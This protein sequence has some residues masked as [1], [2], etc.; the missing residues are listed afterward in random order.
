MTKPF[1]QACENNKAP[2][3][4]VLESV[5]SQATRVLEIGSGTGQHA[6]HFAAALPHVQWQTSDVPAHHEGINAWLNEAALP[7]LLPPVALQVGKDAFPA[8]G[9]DAV[10]S[11]N[12]AHIMFAD[13]VALM[14]TGIAELLPDG[15]VFCQ[16]GPFIQQG[17]FSSESNRAF[18]HNLLL[19]GLGGY[20]SIEDLQAW[21][22]VSLKLKDI[23]AMPA[24]NLCLL[25]QKQVS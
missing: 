16:Y 2:I 17:E 24:N 25:W 23:I 14:M 21:S 4:A 7:N 13:E 10:Y 20:K 3:L 1:S 18:H 5:F 22:G 12:T 8:S 15:G 6:V 11:A 19:R 9:Y